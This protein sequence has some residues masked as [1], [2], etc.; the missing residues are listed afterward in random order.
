MGLEIQRLSAIGKTF[1]FLCLSFIFVATIWPPLVYPRIDKTDTDGDGWPDYFEQKLKTDVQDYES[2]PNPTSDS[3]R[4]GL[5]NARELELGTDP[6]DPD[7]D[8]DKLSDK[9]ETAW[10]I[11]D[12]LSPDTDRDGLSDFSEIMKGSDPNN[13]DSDGDG[14]LDSAEYELGSNPSNA[15][16]IPEKVFQNE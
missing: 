1:R 5:E 11:S 12:P 6:S 9:Q 3:D 13:P 14:W 16:S 2:V 8:N 4:D 7:T 10:G 15:A